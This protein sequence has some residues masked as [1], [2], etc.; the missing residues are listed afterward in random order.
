MTTLKLE[1][2]KQATIYN[3][4]LKAIKRQLN[5]KQLFDLKK[6]YNCS[7]DNQL[8]KITMLRGIQL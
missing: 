4:N 3:K 6:L 2:Q 5:S 8:A 1:Y 7:D